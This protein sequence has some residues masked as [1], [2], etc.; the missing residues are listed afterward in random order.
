MAKI[1]RV[2]SNSADASKFKNQFAGCVILTHDNKILLQHRPE[3]WNN[4][5]GYQ[6]EFGGHI[7][8]GETPSQAIVRELKEELG[9]RVNPDELVALGAVTEDMTNHSEIVYVFFWHDRL[10]SI[11]GCYEGEPRY[12]N[13]IAEALAHPKMVDSVRWLLQ[14][15]R[16]KGLM[17]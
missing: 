8:P 14:E 1:W 6:A 4:Y 16:D 13:N 2:D 7:E 15:C 10:G 17:E 9:A 12:Y 3:N 5:P 11:T